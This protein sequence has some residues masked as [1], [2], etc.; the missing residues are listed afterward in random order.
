VYDITGLW[1]Y[2]AKNERLNEQSYGV[3]QR[4]GQTWAIKYE[5]SFFDGPRRESEFSF[6]VEVQLLKF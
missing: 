3:W 5:V 6:A 2:D 4:L 1:R